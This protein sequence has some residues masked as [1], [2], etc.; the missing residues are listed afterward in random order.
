[1]YKRVKSIEDFP[2]KIHSKLKELRFNGYDLI[3]KLRNL[4]NEFNLQVEEIRKDAEDLNILKVNKLT[5]DGDE[6][7]KYSNKGE[8]NILKEVEVG[9]SSISD[10]MEITKNG[11]TLTKYNSVDGISESV[12]TK[13][14]KGRDQATV[15]ED[16]GLKSYNRKVKVLGDTAKEDTIAQGEITSNETVPGKGTINRGIKDSAYQ[17]MMYG[18][19]TKNINLDRDKVV[20]SN[21]AEKEV[22]IKSSVVEG[23][24]HLN[25]D[26]D[27]NGVTVDTPN[28]KV[29]MKDAGIDITTNKV[30]LSGTAS[31]NSFKEDLGVV[32]KKPL[33]DYLEANYTKLVVYN[34]RVTKVD[35]E[36]G[37]LR[38]RATAIETKSSS[39]A[40]EIQKLKDENNSLKSRLASLESRVSTIESK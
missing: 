17:N 39:N 8:H 38:S 20:E 30:T 12:Q 14:T 11:D 35:Q 25:I 34:A 10:T 27:K 19:T 32:T 31:Q 6:V 7:Q 24:Q 5:Q 16:F 22:K 40:T 36:L 13:I 37:T 3:K 9:P 15:K 28:N 29:Y 23:T 4:F 33:V 26:L 1:M 2:T 18:K 21:V